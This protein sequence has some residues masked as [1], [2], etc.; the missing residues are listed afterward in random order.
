MTIDKFHIWLSTALPGTWDVGS[1]KTGEQ[2]LALYP[3][4]SFINP[5]GIG[6]ETTYR[7]RAIRVLVHWNKN[8][9]ESQTK[10]QEVYSYI[11]NATGAIDGKRIINPSMRDAEAIYLGADESGIFEFVIDCEIIME[12]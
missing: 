3:G 1:L 12:R 6:Q 4:R 9:L 11:R 10:A 7:G 8:I 2:R 5:R